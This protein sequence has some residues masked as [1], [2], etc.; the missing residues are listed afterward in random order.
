MLELP[1][2]ELPRRFGRQ[3]GL[4]VAL[5]KVDGAHRLTFDHKCLKASEW[6]N[7]KEESEEVF[8]W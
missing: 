2:P 5:S 1:M 8:G 4:A 7:Q 6:Y 3:R